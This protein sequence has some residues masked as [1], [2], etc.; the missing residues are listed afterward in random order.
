MGSSATTNSKSANASNSAANSNN[1]TNFGTNTGSTSGSNTVAN[2][3][4]VQG[5]SQAGQALIT[6]ATSP[7][8]TIANTQ[9]FMNPYQQNV[10]NATMQQLAQQ[11]GVQQSGIIG[12]A[13]SNNAL[14][15][16]RE[17]VARE[18]GA[19]QFEQQVAAPTLSNL[20]STGYNQALGTAMNTNA[21]QLQGAGL[22]GTQGSTS[23]NTGNLS[24]QLSSTLGQT[25]GESSQAGSQAGTS[26]GSSTTTQDPGALGYAG[27]AMGLLSS[28]ER[29]KENIKPVGRT[30][31]GQHI[32]KFNYV[33]DHTTHVGL[34]AQE[35]E[36]HHPEAVHGLG[37]LKFVDYDAA[38]KDAAQRK[39][40]STGGAVAGFAD[41][42]PA[43]GLVQ[44]TTQDGQTAWVPKSSV[45]GTAQGAG[46]LGGLSAQNAM[47]M[48]NLGSKAG[49]T[50][51]NFLG[52]TSGSPSSQGLASRGLQSLFGSSSPATT[53][54]AGWQTGTQTSG[55]LGS[56]G[57]MNSAGQGLSSL[58][59]SVSS[60][61]SSL[62][63]AFGFASGGATA[64]PAAVTM[65][66][67]GNSN[68]PVASSP[69][70]GLPSSA[71][72]TPAMAMQANPTMPS[73]GAPSVAMPGLAAPSMEQAAMPS[74]SYPAYGAVSSGEGS[75]A[76]VRGLKDGGLAKLL[77]EFK[78]SGKVPGREDGGG[79]PKPSPVAL[80]DDGNPLDPLAGRFFGSYPP[81]ERAAPQAPVSTGNLDGLKS[82]ISGLLGTTPL[83]GESTPLA[84]GRGVGDVAV[85]AMKRIGELKRSDPAPLP[86][87]NTAAAAP[88]A[89]AGGG[90]T[91]PAQ[92]MVQGTTTPP[93]A[94][95]AK[96]V[97]EPAPAAENAAPAAQAIQP[98][99][100]RNNNP[101]NI[102]YG[103]FAKANGAT[104]NDGRFAI[105]PSVEHGL[106]ATDKLLQNYG[107]QGIDTV[108]GVIGKWAP[109]SENNVDAYS[110]F[111]ATQMGVAPDAKLNM[112]DPKVR[113][114]LAQAITQYEN[115]T[116]GTAGITHGAGGLTQLANPAAAKS[117]PWTI[118]N[119]TDNLGASLRGSPIGQAAYGN[120]SGLARMAPAVSALA[121]GPG[122]LGAS[123]AMQEQ[124]QLEMNQQAQAR[125]QAQQ[126]YE[127]ATPKAIGQ[128]QTQYVDAFG[129]P[130]INTIP[131]YGTYD[132]STGKFVSTPIPAGT[133]AAQGSQASG[134]QDFKLDDKTLT[135]RP[136]IDYVQTINPAVAAYASDVLAGR[137]NLPNVA[138][139]NPGI[140]AAVANV[141]R[142][143]DP[144]YNANRYHYAQAYTDPKGKVQNSLG[145]FETA[146]HHAE[147]IHD[148]TENLSDSGMKGINAVS[149]A[150]QRQFGATALKN[151]DDTSAAF[152]KEVDKAFVGGVGT[153]GEREAS[154]A[155]VSS[156]QPKPAIRSGNAA[157]V[158]LMIGKMLA[159]E[160][161][162]VKNQGKNVPAPPS[163]T[164]DEKEI[165]R[166]IFAAEPNPDVKE[167]RYKRLNKDPRTADLVNP[168]SVVQAGS[169]AAGASNA[170]TR[171]PPRRPAKVPAGAWYAASTGLWYDPQTHQAIQ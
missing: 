33:G 72:Y 48:Y 159:F 40:F 148:S 38:T 65:P 36:K 26:S 61:L 124:Q 67:L 3:A 128:A 116:K 43:D 144:S 20:Y 160:N 41:G 151:F 132:Q 60:G 39:H 7:A 95:I 161:Q 96:P 83:E 66:A 168:P 98:R 100:L 8:N 166:K 57:V 145:S 23:A 62:G 152:G 135:G 156:S 147:T 142:H 32:Y 109:S 121:G 134:G 22:A 155:R 153:G 171:E 143:A 165:A 21:Q 75:G 123:K 79:S 82:F 111:V 31:D 130:H 35:V 106:A 15:G 92:P 42:G 25:L 1:A 133:M 88:L 154:E 12:N 97:A 13:I 127:M 56:G 85:D 59:N 110:G 2:T 55:A 73:F 4:N 17:A 34:L 129:I 5:P 157:N 102:E 89:P 27:L 146:L 47:Q 101:G 51:S 77:A 158:E 78:G 162:W 30:F 46:G 86:D 113:S 64:A 16:D 6:S 112:G 120:L 19:T 139:A 29:V 76:A 54:A 37:A 122:G 81:A 49:N 149:N 108:Q 10:V 14:G 45:S 74:V 131:Q 69:V 105:F 18:L 53:G 107:T 138:K 163:L 103:S 117:Q 170:A 80:G 90:L 136:Y 140:G 9:A 93:A 91:G 63:G 71:F 125:A 84:S 87:T 52:G 24:Q 70:S 137:E 114:S 126:L 115:G 58:G 99:G 50:L 11:S 119:F 68:V 150:I 118:G 164:D 44:V 141:V 167:Q 94:A 169:T 28:D 104:G